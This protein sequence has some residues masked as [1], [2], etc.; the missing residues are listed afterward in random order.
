MSAQIELSRSEPD[1]A[2]DAVPSDRL[3][4]TPCRDAG[5]EA[6]AES[7]ADAPTRRDQRVHGIFMFGLQGVCTF[8]VIGFIAAILVFVP[9]CSD[10]AWAVL[11]ASITLE[12]LSYVIVATVL[13]RMVEWKR[14]SARDGA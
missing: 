7:A 5:P 9:F 2:S 4:S 14:Q 3:P 11:K 6:W 8:A 13:S 12:A 1:A 10:A